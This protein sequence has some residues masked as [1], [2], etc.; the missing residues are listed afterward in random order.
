MTGFRLRFTTVIQWTKWNPKA[1]QRN[2]NRFHCKIGIRPEDRQP[3]SNPI[4][5]KGHPWGTLFYPSLLMTFEQYLKAHNHPPNLSGDLRKTVYQTYRKW[6]KRQHQRQ[7]RKERKRLE[8]FP[9][10]RELNLIQRQAKKHHLAASS[11]ALKAIMAYLQQ[12]YIVPDEEEIKSLQLALHKIGTNINQ[13]AFQANKNKFADT[14]S[15]RLLNQQL[16]RLE[17][18]II[19][20]L[21]QPQNLNTLVKAALDEHPSYARILQRILDRHS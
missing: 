5:P 3:T 14:H 13:I 21:S 15:I 1:K 19:Q 4:L 7:R 10:D 16:S 12:L 18:L 20:K 8:I 6:Y 11:F 9:S 17:Q 2:A